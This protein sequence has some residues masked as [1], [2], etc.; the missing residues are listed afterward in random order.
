M[1]RFFLMIRALVYITGFVAFWGWLALRLNRVVDG[2]VPALPSAV[3]VPGVVL[4]LLG[5]I[6]A[7]TCVAT[8]VLQGRGTP[9][10]FDPPR[11]FVP[12]GPYRWVRNPMYLGALLVLVGFGLWR[13]SLT[14]ILF[15]FAAAGAAHLFVVFYEEPTLKRRFGVQYMTY[16]MLVHR[17][18]PKRPRYGWGRPP[19]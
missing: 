9:A 13:T 15:A 16:L 17:W 18:L 8:F 3:Q 12:T 4:I 1:T 14:M 19:N 2:A 11:I 10:P 5:A 6:V 7:L